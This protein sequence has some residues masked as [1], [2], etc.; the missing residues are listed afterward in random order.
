MTA[1]PAT[2]RW[3]RVLPRY[4]AGR[5]RRSLQLRLVVTTLVVSGAVVLLLGLLLLQQV[6]HG[7][8]DAKTRTA[9]AEAGSGLNIAQNQLSA[10][11]NAD[12]TGDGAS[13]QLFRLTL[14]LA[15]R[16]DRGSD[17]GLFDVAV[18]AGGAGSTA[19]PVISG[20]LEQSSIP[21]G[22]RRAVAV[23]DRQAYMF[24][25]IRHATGS[26]QSGSEPGLV[27]GARLNDGQYELYY[28]FSLR[29][30]S[31]TL[32]LVRRTLIFTG[33]MLVLLLAAIVALV[34]RQVVAPV[35]LAARTAERLAAGRLEERMR[36]RGEDEL[37]RLGSSFNRMAGSL[38]GQIRQLEELSR[39]QRRFVADVSHELR[40]PLTTIRMA[41]DV[42]HEARPS[43]PPEVARS[44]ELLQNQLDRF[45]A[46]L[47]DLLEISRYDAG[48]NVLEAE[49]ADLGELVHRVLSTAEP[50]AQRRGSTLLVHQPAAP[51]VAE[52][53]PRRIERI[54]RNLV[55]NAIEHGE[56]RP[57]DVT[58]AGTAQAAA[59]TVR[60]RGV[61]LRPGESAQVFARFWRADP[62]R[63]RATGGTGLGLSIS[64]EDARLH[65]GWLQAWGVPGRGTLF[66][67]TVP[68]HAG[69][70]LTG[71]PLPL[72]PA[73]APGEPAPAS[74]AA[75]P[76]GV[77]DA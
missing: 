4:T 6:T 52:V 54:L 1:V 15:N 55:N 44:A 39:L 49:P 12:L 50:L 10:S 20:G 56:G 61:G 74:A 23:S 36:V 27:I 34:T 33:L 66:R 47:T 22:L 76:A 68:L 73:A 31:A 21:D 67:L 70:P 69:A 16:G 30:E 77:R 38:Q 11:D 19:T 72:D 41:A 29:Q 62:A 53:D 42:L 25:R 60:D 43:F 37:A 63:A 2:L 59:L 13:N 18:L 5:W 26:A 58:L 51:V 71:S 48:A 40:T 64:L 14:G 9:L 46:L 32:A 35:Q 28:L 3:A 65:G 24:T 45:E 17:G 57:I 8:L 75:L 7:I